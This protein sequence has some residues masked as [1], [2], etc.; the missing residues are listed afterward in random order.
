MDAINKLKSEVS[1]LEH[2]QKTLWQ[3]WKN[4]TQW[5]RFKSSKDDKTPS[6]LVYKDQTKW[7]ND[8][9]WILW[10]WTIID[11]QMKF[12]NQEMKDA[13]KTLCDT[14]NIQDDNKKEF[15]KSPKRFILAESF[16]EYRQSWNTAWFTRFLWTR[17]IDFDFIQQNKDTINELAK[18]FW[19]CE[20]V[21][22][23]E[24][25]YKDVIIFPCL[26]TWNIVGCKL[27]TTDKTP[28]DFKWK[29]LKSVSVWKP[30]DYKWKFP[31]STGLIYKELSEKYVLIVEWETDYIILKLLWFKSVIWNLWWVST[32]ADEIQSLI[33]TT[34][35]IVCLYDNDWPWIL[36]T[37]ILQ[38]KVWR[39][40]RKVLYPKIEG[41]DKYDIN[42]LFNMWY[43]KADFNKLIKES[44]L[45]DEAK[46][47]EDQPLY[48]KR[49]FYDNTKLEYF[50]IKDFS[51][52]KANNLA[53]HLFVKPWELEDFREGWV[54]PTY[55]WICYFDWGKK[56]FFNLLDKS[57]MCHP[58]KTPDFCT[59]FKDLIYNLCNNKEENVKWLLEAIIYKYT[60]LNDVIIPAVVFHWVGWTWKWLL[61]KLLSEIFWSN[62]TQTWLTQ[63]HIDSQFSTYSWQKLIVEFKEL[64]VDNTAK[65]KR[66][67]QKLKTFI[68]EDNIMIRKMRQDAIS[69]ENIAWFMMS[70]NEAK[71]IQLDSVDSGNRRFTIIRTWD[72]TGLI[73]GWKIAEAIKKK[74]NVENFIAWL[75]QEFPDIKNKK[76]ILPLENEDKR[77]LENLSESVWNLF[78][79]WFEEE[80]PNINVLRNDER[81]DLIAIYRFWYEKDDDINDDRYKIQYFN[82]WLSMRYKTTSKKIE[83][84]VERCTTIK[85]DVEW[86]WYF[87]IWFTAKLRELPKAKGNE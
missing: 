2:I 14:Y 61:M 43:K 20:N 11:F 60:H 73:K 4:E 79:K 66:N 44:V 22:I 70:S 35:Q 36:A 13:I 8:Y 3:S 26:K 31:F 86:K 33:K 64:S 51:F 76:N 12:Y 78:F 48:K 10:G 74:E 87:D 1:L 85:K 5:V 15:K 19:I 46:K 52:Q 63:E 24:K 65:G 69:V 67:M 50:D 56:N 27:R 34:K 25:I 59:E 83:W 28:F 37:N 32:N 23:K 38:E 81:N 58:S 54:I 55:E 53:R 80:Y 57:K 45:L 47:S 77:D 30:K 39:P 62:N 82:A 21:W 75:L 49:F 42:D 72:A 9:S 17:W 6:L 16:E 29:G 7:Y 40:I 68:M 84:K 41:K 18:E 71:P